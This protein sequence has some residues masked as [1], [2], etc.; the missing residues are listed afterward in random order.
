MT[1]PPADRHTT[2]ALARLIAWGRVGI[3]ITALGAPA[4]MA[5]PWIGA[6]ASGPGART[7]ARAM[8]GRDIALG[9]GAL[10]AL[11]D[12][13]EHARAW[14]ALGGTA[15]AVDALAT[16]VAFSSLPRRSRW[17]MLAVTGGAAIVSIRLASSLDEPAGT[18]PE[19]SAPASG[20]A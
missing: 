15:D 6:E 10:R 9:I 2:R 18:V 3:G 7:L 4:L 1:M 19:P 17:A 12:S 5:R 16:V 14:V 8:G 13:D 20:S 11:T